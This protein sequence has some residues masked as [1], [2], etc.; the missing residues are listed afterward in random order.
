MA[1]S[2][3]R[4]HAL[5]LVNLGIFLLFVVGQAVSGYFDQVST[6]REHFQAGEGFVSYLGSGHFLEA[7]FENWESEF[8]QI[9]AFVT[10]TALLAQKGSSQSHDPEAVPATGGEPRAD[11]RS[12]FPVRRGGWLL[13]LYRRSLGLFFLLLFLASIALHA[14]TGL[15]EYNEDLQRHGSDPVALFGYVGSSRF[16]FESFQNWQSEFLAVWLLVVVSI[17]LRQEGSPES[18]PVEAPADSTGSG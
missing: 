17:W 8:L 13:A 10:L 2:F 16:W 5:S 1:R 14:V 7:L 9:W 11:D 6:G 12:P 4:T 15:A 18:K 3:L